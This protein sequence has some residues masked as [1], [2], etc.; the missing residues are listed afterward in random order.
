MLIFDGDLYVDLNDEDDKAF[1]D[2]LTVALVKQTPEAVRHAALKVDSFWDAHV[3][4]HPSASAG[5]FMDETDSYVIHLSPIIPH[6]TP[7]QDVIID[8][9]IAL[10]PK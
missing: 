8:I 5:G 1:K 9:V 6:D 3:A 2:I 7:A 4:V 10:R